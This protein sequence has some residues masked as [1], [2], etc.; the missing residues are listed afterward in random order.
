MTRVLV[1]SIGGSP[2]IDVAR[3]LRRDP[4]V[5]IVGADANAWG[6]QL[7]QRL[8]DEVIPLPSARADAVA[9]LDAVVDASRGVDFVFLGLD[10]EIEA[11][12]EAGT[13][14]PV[15]TALAPMHVLPLL[16]DKAKTERAASCR[17]P[18]SF[19]AR[20]PWT[21]CSRLWL[22]RCGSAPP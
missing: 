13:P 18:S 2:G 21:R 3:C 19:R 11:L 7:G 22:R 5:H 20:Q 14:L 16:V 6:R 9:W 12:A 17:A 15:A 1:T 8:C 10:L 4:S